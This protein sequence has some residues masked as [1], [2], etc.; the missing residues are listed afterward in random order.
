MRMNREIQRLHSAYQD[1]IGGH[2]GSGSSIAENLLQQLS[3]NSQQFLC[4]QNLILDPTNSKLLLGLYDA[5]SIWLN[6]LARIEKIELRNAAVGFAPHI[7]EPIHFPIANE[8]PV[9]LKYVPEFFIENIVGFL[10]FSRV[11][12]VQDIQFDLDARTSIF[13]MILI[14]MGSDK[15]AKN[16]HLRAHLAEGLESFLPKENRYGSY[17]ENGRKLF[18]SHEHRLFIVENLLNVFVSIEMTGQVFIYCTNTIFILKNHV[19]ICT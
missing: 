10:Q 14:F 1:A 12:G 19:F 17:Q 18:E 7:L 8:T 9:L 16:P 6:Q 13:T 5:T 2:G 4:L 15:R 3:A 11:F